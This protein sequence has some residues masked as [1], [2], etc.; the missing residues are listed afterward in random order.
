MADVNGLGDFVTQG[1]FG[2]PFQSN[3][4]VECKLAI[5]RLSKAEDGQKIS[6]AKNGRNLAEMYLWPRVSEK[7]EA[8][9]Y[10]AVYK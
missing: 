1:G 5:S 10:D 9:Y 7:I 6:W 3:S 4:P 2:I 8:V